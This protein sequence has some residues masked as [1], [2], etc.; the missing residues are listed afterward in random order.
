MI[1]QKGPQKISCVF[2]NKSEISSYFLNKCVSK[3]N[4]KYVNKL[5][6]NEY[7]TFTLMFSVLH[8]LLLSTEGVISTDVFFKSEMRTLASY[9]IMIVDY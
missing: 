6:S 7:I 8:Y 1:S 4:C 3:W 2:P 5:S 9:K